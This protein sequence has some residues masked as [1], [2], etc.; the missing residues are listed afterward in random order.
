MKQFVYADNA[1]TTQISKEVLDAMMPWLTE[2]YGNPSSIYELGRTAG[3]AIEDARKQVAAALGAQPAEIYFTGCGSESDNWA[4]K[5]AA[6]K[7]AAKGKKHLITTVFEHHAV[8][9][10]CAALEKEGF[11][12]TYLP[13]DHNGLITAQ[14]VADAIRPDTALVSIMYANNEIGTIMPIPEIGALC[15]ERG[16]WFHTDAVQAV[17]NIEID[18]AAQNIDML[19]L[20]G[21]KIHAPKGIGAL[22]IKKGI[23]LPNL[24]DGGEQERGRRAGTEN[25]ASIIGLGRAM[26]IACADIPAKI[27]KVTPL[28]NKMIDELLTL[29]MSRLNGDR[30]RRL[31]GN[32]NLSFV[33]AEGEAL[34]LG[35]DMAG[36]CASSGSACTTGSL[37]PSHVLLALGLSHEVAHGSLRITISDWTT[38]EEVDH[39][40]DS[41]KAVVTRTRDIS[42]LWE[43]IQKGRKTIAL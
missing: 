30:E 36:V 39:I 4:I 33:G 27:S 5:G 13:V 25:V 35:L 19:S 9:H 14:Q 3:F 2:G 7:L 29:P 8:L 28:R 31:A 23:V 43:D 34:L 38:P 18:V 12:I 1:A 20:S 37:D 11:E 24:I 6:H 17:G 10:T 32:T 16:V 40:I 21:H 41:V 15:R 22:Y 42:P 26:E